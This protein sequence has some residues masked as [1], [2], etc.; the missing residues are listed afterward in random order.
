MPTRHKKTI[1]RGGL[2]IAPGLSA[3]RKVP[4][5]TPGRTAGDQR[6]PSIIGIV[7]RKTPFESS[8]AYTGVWRLSLIS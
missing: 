1:N 5:S 3:I 2:P 4:R 6:L 7:E 8:D